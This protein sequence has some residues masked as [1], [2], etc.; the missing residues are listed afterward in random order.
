MLGFGFLLLVSLVLSA[1]VAVLG[2][3][4][5]GLIPGW[6]VIGYLLSYGIS[7]GLV[8]LVLAAIFKVLP[9]V[10]I[11]WRDVW[12]GALVTSVLFHVGKFG[13]SVYIGKAGVALE[14]RRRGLAGGPARLDLL[15]VA[16]RPLRRGVH[17]RLRQRVRQ[18]RRPERQRPARPGDA[19]GA[20]RAGEE[21]QERRAPRLERGS[22]KPPVRVVDW[23]VVRRIEVTTKTMVMAA[24]VAGGAWI[25]L[26]LAPVALVLVVAFFLVGTLNPIVEWLEKKKVRRGVGIATVFV[27]MLLLLV[28]IVALTVPALIDQVTS[29]VREE[30]AL[31]ARVVDALSHSRMTAPLAE[32]IRKLDYKALARGSVASAFE[33][34]VR[35]VE[36]VAYLATSVFLALYIMIDRDRLRGGLYAVVARRHHIR[37]SRVLLNLE[38]IVGGYIRGQIVTSALMAGFTFVLLTACGVK[39]ALAI[40]AIAGVADILP[41]IGV[42]LSV[43]PAVAA[44]A[45]R[46]VVVVVIV[47]VA[48]LGYEEIESRFLVP[49]IYGNVLKLPSSVVLFSLLAGGELMGIPGA[50]LALPVAAAVRMLIEELR[51]ELPGEV[52]DNSTLRAGDARAERDY[53]RRAEG[54]PAAEAAAIAVEIT[55]KRAEAEDR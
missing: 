19:A 20:R 54:V 3:W 21:A 2:S 14:L 28:G 49:R 33:Y 37:L 31:R 43:G 23:S 17:A 40:G 47:L 1:A 34:S 48:M 9:D 50:L 25:V 42:F 10:E 55:E 12:V 26:R 53:E 24:L 38:I 46:G 51:I 7:L 41:Y 52:V 22:M 13:I 44:A 4:I 39:A 15:L 6:I 16:D 27:A 18:P 29:L 45:P 8:A 30:P 5:G 36:V 32:S 35:S 11:S